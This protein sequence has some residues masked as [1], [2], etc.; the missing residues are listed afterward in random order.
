[1]S[2]LDLRGSGDW[3]VDVTSDGI[4]LTSPFGK[5]I[6]LPAST[7]AFAGLMTAV[8]KGRV[9]SLATGDWTVTPAGSD[10]ILTSPTGQT[11]TIPIPDTPSGGGTGLD[12][13]TLE[14]ENSFPADA[15]VLAAIPG[16][17]NRP[18]ISNRRVFSSVSSGALVLSRTLA[19][20]FH[21][22]QYPENQGSPR[23]LRRQYWIGTDNVVNAYVPEHLL[24]PV[25]TTADLGTTDGIAL[26]MHD[27]L[28]NDPEGAL[29]IDAGEGIVVLLT[30]F[31]ELNLDFTIID[32]TGERDIRGQFIENGGRIK[33]R[34]ETSTT[35]GTDAQGYRTC[36]LYTSPSPRDS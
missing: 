7:E 29:I 33:S 24:Q 19:G 26:A 11:V 32:R 20:A 35:P 23:S 34:G 16:M 5:T 15:K 30:S 2:I 13:D 36:L 31:N 3:R 9:N 8:D 1:M 12:L 14:D 10:V 17:Q 25:P 4:R 27:A 6:T 22:N 28:G 21:E 18:T